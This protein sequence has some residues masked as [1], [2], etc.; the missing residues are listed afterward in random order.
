MDIS[1]RTIEP[2]ELR[3]YF[4]VIETAFGGRLSNGFLA[5]HRPHVELERS[6]AAFDGDAIVGAAGVT[7]FVMTVPGGEIPAAGVTGVGVLP[8]HRR[9]G[10]NTALMRTQLEDV[11]ARGET[12]AVLYASQGSIY[13]RFGY[14]LASMNAAIDVE[15]QRSAFGPWYVPSGRVRLVERGEAVTALLPVYDEIRRSRPGMMRLDET[16]FAYRLD[17]RFRDDGKQ[18][19]GFYAVHETEGGVVDGYAQ[20][21]VR[22]EWDVFAKN[23]VMVED[24]IAVSARAYAD[25]WRY[26][27]DTDLVFRVTAWNRPSD[28]PLFHL[29]LEARPLQF[30]LKDAL[31]LRIVDVER[32]LAA[33]AYRSETSIVLDVADAFCGW[34]EGR[35]EVSTAAAGATC[36]RTEREPDLVLGVAELG[37]AF[38][39]GTRIAQLARAGR[40]EERTPRAVERADA[41]FAWD[42]APWCSIMF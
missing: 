11:R 40:I 27:L 23:E 30:R 2:G 4:S 19:E 36:R 10:V 12:V 26:V 9:R 31:W 22:H 32:A 15:T 29:V 38:L 25:L 21:R 6:H 1:I 14:G 5:F 20:Y 42:P 17:D 16:Q 8:T 24:L 7:S 41:A 39:G 18:L 28:D 35:Y 3:E 34:N 37:A 13:G 33:R